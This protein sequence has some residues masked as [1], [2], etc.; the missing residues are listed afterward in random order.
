MLTE[1]RCHQEFGDLG[2]SAVKGLLQLTQETAA[3][4]NL[5]T[6]NPLP[7]RDTGPTT[8][9]VLSLLP[10]LRSTLCPWLP[11][12]YLSTTHVLEEPGCPKDPE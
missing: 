12:R 10:K 11:I 9:A 2:H 4:V 8:I 6:G 5:A 7:A 3:T 1:L